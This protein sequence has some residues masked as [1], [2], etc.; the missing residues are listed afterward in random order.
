MCKVSLHQKLPPSPHSV[1][2]YASPPLDL[3]LHVLVSLALCDSKS[4]LAML[5]YCTQC[6]L[7]T[8]ICGRQQVR[9]WLFVREGVELLIELFWEV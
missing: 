8:T 2:H 9:A 3:T 5:G 7:T 4:I 6:C 1:D